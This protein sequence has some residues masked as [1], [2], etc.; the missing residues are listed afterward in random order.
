MHAKAFPTNVDSSS[1]LKP[2]VIV[3][4]GRL[5]AAVWKLPSEDG[6][7]DYRFNVFS[8][9]AIDGSVAH[10]FSARDIID[11]AKLAH[12]LAA[13]LVDDGCMDAGLRRKLQS[14]IGDLEEIFFREAD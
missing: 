8:L 10:V 11:L 1:Q 7:A 9:D 2:Y 14:L 5:S 3:G 13:V 6:E 4:A 12:V